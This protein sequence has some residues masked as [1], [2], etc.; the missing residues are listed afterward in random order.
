MEPVATD[1][2]PTPQRYMAILVVGLGVTMAVLDGAIAN[3][4]LP[5]IARDLHATPA[6]S[7]WVVN[8]YQLIVM[9]SLLPLSSLGER[10]GGASGML[11]TAR[12]LGQ[13]AGAALVALIF[14]LHGGQGTQAV[15]YTT[16]C[17]ALAAMVMSSLRLTGAGRAGRGQL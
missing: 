7:V 15:L 14:N 3:I 11:G 9:M 17:F 4:A 6:Q 16:A 13:T 10:T 5:T 8:A 2:L 12:L 1:G